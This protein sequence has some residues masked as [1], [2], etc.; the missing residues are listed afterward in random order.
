MVAVR[1]DISRRQRRVRR[2]L[3]L[4]TQAPRQHRRRRDVRLHIARRHQRSR[5]RRR[6]RRDVQICHRNVFDRFRRVERRC[7]IQPVIQCVQQSVINPESAA[8]RGLPVAAH[9]PRKPHARIQQELRPVRCQ[10]G[11]ADHRICLQHA[12]HKGVVRCAPARL[13]PAIARLGP[14]PRAQLQTRPH[15]P[16]VFHERRALQRPPSQLCRRRHHRERRHR[17]L[18]KRLQCAERGLPILILRQQ[19]VRLDPLHPPA[20]FQLMISSRVVTLVVTREQVPR[21]HI[22]AADVGARQRDLRS[23]VRRRAAADHDR[24]DRL[25]FHPSR[26]RNRRVAGEVVAPSRVPEPRNHPECQFR[27]GKPRNTKPALRRSWRGV[28]LP[29]IRNSF[30]SRRQ[31]RRN[32]AHSCNRIDRR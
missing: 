7:L 26:H 32:S 11:I 10:R 29:A 20:R 5:G 24:S 13:I 18:Q 9:I 30:R 8:H 12:I 23:A 27:R 25:A 2:H 14:E 19:I 3:L 22:V 15:F 21:R 17:P 31:L 4:Q 6:S 16:G 28:T 1:P